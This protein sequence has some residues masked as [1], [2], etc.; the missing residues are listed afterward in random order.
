MGTRGGLCVLC[1]GSSDLCC[2]HTDGKLEQKPGDVCTTDWCFWHPVSS[3]GFVSNWQL[4]PAKLWPG[5]AP[6]QVIQVEV[7]CAGP[8]FGLAF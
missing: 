8:C 6:H 1:T 3:Q 7:L 5:T 2:T 4:G